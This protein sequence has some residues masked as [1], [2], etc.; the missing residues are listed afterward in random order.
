MVNPLLILQARAEA[1]ARLFELGEF[2][3]L[4]EALRPLFDFA[5]ES[6]IADG[7]GAD[8][9]FAIVHKAFGDFMKPAPIDD[10]NADDDFAKSIDLAYELIRERKAAGGKGW[11]PPS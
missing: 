5:L 7:I 2:D 3:S 1:R 11:E 6:G 10:Y 4:D 8:A 9:M